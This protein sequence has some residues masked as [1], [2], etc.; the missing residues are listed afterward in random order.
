MRRH[1]TTPSPGYPEA[2]VRL[3]R[4]DKIDEFNRRMPELRQDLDEV[5]AADGARGAGR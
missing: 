2:S 3:I 1:E 4:Q 5:V